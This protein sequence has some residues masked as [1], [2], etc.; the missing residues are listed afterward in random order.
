MRWPARLV[1][2]TLFS[3]FRMSTYVRDARRNQQVWEQ[4]YWSQRTGA[5]TPTPDERRVA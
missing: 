3:L 5:G 4:R 1:S 2:R